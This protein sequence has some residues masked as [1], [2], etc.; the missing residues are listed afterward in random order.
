MKAPEPW[1]LEQMH[2]DRKNERLTGKPAC[3]LCEQVIQDD[4]WYQ[5]FGKVVCRSCLDSDCLVMAEE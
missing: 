1:E 2:E 5:V 3:C 4:Y